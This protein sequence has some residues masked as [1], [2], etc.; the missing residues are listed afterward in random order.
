VRILFVCTGNLCR[1]PFAE[2]LA[3][4]W[5]RTMLASS[6]EAL[7]VHIESAGLVATPGQEMDP[8]TVAA[9]RRHG[10]TSDGFR[11]QSLTKELAQTADLVITMTREQRRAVL[12]LEP[13]GLRKTFT[14]TEA[15][16][17]LGGADLGGLS[18]T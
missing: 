9:L 12:E 14:L 3:T 11:S 10:I 16:D 2:R 4:D 5:A 13:R 1:S 8:H 15:A 6:P 17:L 7:N 18:V